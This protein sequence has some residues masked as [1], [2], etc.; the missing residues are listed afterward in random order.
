MR[1]SA[2]KARPNIVSVH[3]SPQAKAD[4]D[5]VCALRGMTIKT[6]LGRLIE[7]FVQLDKTEQ[8]VVLGQVEDVDVHELAQLI[9][10]RR[11]KYLADDV[12]AAASGAKSGR[13]R[14]AAR[15]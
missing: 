2:E 15:A 7:W 3:L 13:G 5:A 6:L 8:S 11:T 1:K 14:R 9:A 10:R 12:G 4:L